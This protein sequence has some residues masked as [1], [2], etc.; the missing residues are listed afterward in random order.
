VEDRDALEARLRERIRAEG[1]IS[2]AAFMEAAL[3]EPGGFYTTIPVG[4]DADFVTSPHVSPAFGSLLARQLAQCWEMLGRPRPFRVVEVGAGDGTLARQMLG[5]AAAA[6]PLAEAMAYE[7]VERSAAARR[8]L[9]ESGMRVGEALEDAA[10]VVLANELLDNLPFHRLR[11]RGGVTVEV[12]VDIGRRGFVE[13]EGPPTPEALQALDRELEPGEERPVSP[14]ALELVDRIA[15]ALAPGYAF[16][17]DYGF[18]EG[19]RPGEVHAYARHR[20]SGDVL[21]EPGSRD[22]TAA[23]DLGAI[24]ARAGRAG[25]QVW[26]PVSQR[27]ALLG[28]GMRL[29]LQ[30]VRRRTEE[31]EGRGD[32]NEARRLFE[33]RSRAS[34]LIDEA[35][36][37]SLRLLVLGSEGLPAPA[38]ALGDRE[39]G[40]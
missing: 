33:A 28:L 8:A 14:A 15:G 23:V 13:V 17:F 9:T 39:T 22:I 4:A 37:G 3:Y 24:A 16:L 1:P 34:I 26:G 30:G 19:E 27:E 31:A 38:A 11:E 32:H 12:L 2:F 7:A 10:H 21:S 35:K 25:L 5:E 29:W 20:V 18:A 6:A 40:C 36:L